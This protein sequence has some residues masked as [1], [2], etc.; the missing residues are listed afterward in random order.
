MTFILDLKDGGL[1]LPHYWNSHK[2]NMYVT[3]GLPCFHFCSLILFLLVSNTDRM[4]RL[5]TEKPQAEKSTQKTPEKEKDSGFMSFLLK[6]LS[7]LSSPLPASGQKAELKVIERLNQRIREQRMIESPT[8]QQSSTNNSFFTFH[9]TSKEPQTEKVNEKKREEQRQ[10]KVE[11]MGR[12]WEEIER[13]KSE[14][15]SL[16]VQYQLLWQE[17][18]QSNQTARDL[19]DELK[20]RNDLYLFYQS[21][22]TLNFLLH[23]SISHTSIMI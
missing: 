23:R 16:H 22:R 20:V 15:D 7:P 6:S 4:E 1:E 3:D 10:N 11:E 2:I 18:Q 17:L 21:A 5:G 19:Q 8:K 13:L 14:K 12:L 9:S